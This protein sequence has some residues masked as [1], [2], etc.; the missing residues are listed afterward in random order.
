MLMTMPATCVWLLTSVLTLHVVRAER[1]EKRFLESLMD[2]HTVL[3]PTTGNED[4]ALLT[5]LVE[6]PSAARH[7]SSSLLAKKMKLFPGIGD[8]QATKNNVEKVPAQDSVPWRGLASSRLPSVLNSAASSPSNIKWLLKNWLSAS[9]ARPTNLGSHIQPAGDQSL[10]RGTA[11]SD[12]VLDSK[13]NSHLQTQPWTYTADTRKERRSSHRWTFSISY[14]SGDEHTVYSTKGEPQRMVPTIVSIREEQSDESAGSPQE[15]SVRAASHYSTPIAQTLPTPHQRGGNQGAA[16]GSKPGAEGSKSTRPTLDTSMKTAYPS[17]TG[18]FPT[19]RQLHAGAEALYSHYPTPAPRRGG[20]SSTYPRPQNSPAPNLY[21]SLNRRAH[22]LAPTAAPQT[23]APWPNRAP[24]TRIYTHTTTTTT[25]TPHPTPRAPLLGEV[26]GGYFQVFKRPSD[27]TP[28][29]GMMSSDMACLQYVS[30]QHD[31]ECGH[32]SRR[33]AAPSVHHLRLLMQHLGGSPS[34]PFTA[35]SVQEAASQFRNLMPLGIPD[36]DEHIHLKFTT[37]QIEDLLEKHYAENNQSQSTKSEKHYA[38]NNQSQFTKSEK[39]YAEN[40]QSQSTKSEKHYAENNQ[41]QS[42]KSVPRFEHGN[43]SN[44]EADDLQLPV[45]FLQQMVPVKHVTLDSTLRR[46]K[47]SF[48]PGNHQSYACLNSVD[49][50]DFDS[51]QCPS[52]RTEMAVD[53][54]NCDTCRCAVSGSGD[55]YCQHSGAQGSG[56]QNP[57]SHLCTQCQRV[58]HLGPDVFPSY[59]QEVVCHP[60]R[61]PCLDIGGALG[62]QGQCQESQVP[63][64]VLRRNPGR[65]MRIVLTSGQSLVLDDWRPAQQMVRTGCQCMMDKRSPVAAILPR[66]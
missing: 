60:S 16:T 4:G 37:S 59:L 66:S 50:R 51:R 58:R 47:R 26:A 43:A 39:H 24:A 63:I 38:E 15:R 65:C 30:V 20:D 52:G 53:E 23:L 49:C 31:V 57:R 21:N 3:K 61:A 54:N 35:A 32:R 25:T 28:A 22:T 44:R 2:R 29:S 48:D 6:N 41:S 55:G 14:G 34:S 36:V 5:N 40:N 27:P 18:V 33:S 1:F 19:T 42:T 11:T 10:L 46:S 62:P 7:G 45:D 8:I 56:V 12:S 13:Q 9:R 64:S 17:T